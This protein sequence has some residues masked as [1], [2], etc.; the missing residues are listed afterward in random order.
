[1]IS[2]RKLSARFLRHHA[3]KDNPD[4]RLVE[5]GSSLLAVQASQIVT[6]SSFWTL[7]GLLESKW[8]L[9]AAVKFFSRELDMTDTNALCSL[10][11]IKGY[12]NQWYGL[13]AL[14]IGP[15]KSKSAIRYTL[16]NIAQT[17]TKSKR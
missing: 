4:L 17:Q 9:L 10:A 11:A 3:S 5:L 1:M 8:S 13:Y 2:G 7:E 12:S 6:S 14:I 15:I 16:R